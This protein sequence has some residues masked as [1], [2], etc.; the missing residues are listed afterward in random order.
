MSD[1]RHKAR[2]E[3]RKQKRAEKREAK[4]GHLK[5]QGKILRPLYG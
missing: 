5:A 2:E 4:I 1:K 3:R